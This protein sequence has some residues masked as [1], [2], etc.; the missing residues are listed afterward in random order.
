ML[1]YSFLLWALSKLTVWSI[2]FFAFIKKGVCTITKYSAAN[3]AEIFPDTLTFDL[4]SSIG[5]D[6]AFPS[7]IIIFTVFV[8]TSN[9]SEFWFWS[10]FPHDEN[11]FKSFI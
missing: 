1:Q 4:I 5:Y 7:K 8:R 11:I 10:P 9:I 3:A 2:L 6:I